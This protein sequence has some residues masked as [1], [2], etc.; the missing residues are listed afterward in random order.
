[1]AA[2]PLGVKIVDACG[3]SNWIPLSTYRVVHIALAA[4]TAFH[5]E[6]T[7]EQHAI[8]VPQKM[9]NLYSAADPEP[10]A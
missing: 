8:C 4:V 3:A 10:Y 9:L 6:M 5:L 1:M 2:G 7:H